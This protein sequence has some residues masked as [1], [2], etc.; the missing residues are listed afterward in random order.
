MFD[1]TFLESAT[2]TPTQS[3]KARIQFPN[4]KCTHALRGEIL[5]K[6]SQMLVFGPS[7]FMHLTKGKLDRMVLFFHSIPH[8]PP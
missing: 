8:F 7:I 4:M 5:V 2:Q 1:R 6:M 3:T